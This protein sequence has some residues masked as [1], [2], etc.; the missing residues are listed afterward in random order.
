MSMTLEELEAEAE[1]WGTLATGRLNGSMLGAYSRSGRI[2]A[3]S[4]GMNDRQRRCVLAHEI[5]H[6]RHD[7]LSPCDWDHRRGVAMERR[8]DMEAARMLIDGD[9]YRELELV[10]DSPLR[11]AQELDVSL[12]V[13]EAYREWLHEE[14]VVAPEDF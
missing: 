12:W 9:E 1:R 13:V 8:A 5:S 4:A 11:I 3:L 6:A 14:G 2:I 7:D 10:Y